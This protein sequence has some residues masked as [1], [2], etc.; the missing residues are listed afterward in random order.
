MKPRKKQMKTP[1]KHYEAI[2]AWAK[3]ERVEA[4]LKFSSLWYPVFEPDWDIS[5]KYRIKPESKPDI[6]RYV[7]STKD[8]DAVFVERLPEDNLKLTYDGETGF[9]KSA[10]VL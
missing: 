8:D 2:M 7:R 10:E 9:L 5:T 3:G 1:H 6:V 4:Q